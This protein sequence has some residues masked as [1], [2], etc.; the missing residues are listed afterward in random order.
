M[1]HSIYIG[2]LKPPRTH[3]NPILVLDY[4]DTQ[5]YNKSIAQTIESLTCFTVYHNNEGP[6]PCLIRL[7]DP[8]SSKDS[9]TT[10]VPKGASNH[11]TPVIDKL[12][13]KA[14]ATVQKL[15][16]PQES[17]LSVTLPYEALY[18]GVKW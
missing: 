11:P 5:H 3:F 8:T 10:Y 15:N 17:R 16:V 6:S 9:S 1:M 4:I 13:T 7:H 12:E 2:N 14:I 18:N